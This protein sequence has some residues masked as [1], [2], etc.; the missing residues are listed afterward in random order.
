MIL[1]TNQNV[2]LL[3][4]VSFFDYW[5]FNEIDEPVKTTT[6]KISEKISEK[7]KTKQICKEFPDHCVQFLFVS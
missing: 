7:I 3:N 4:T 1:Q 6:E 2:D 5:Q